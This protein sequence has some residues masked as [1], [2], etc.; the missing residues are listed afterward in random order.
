MF[1]WTAAHRCDGTITGRQCHVFGIV[2]ESDIPIHIQDKALPLR[3]TTLFYLTNILGKCY[4]IDALY[5]VKICNAPKKGHT[6]IVRWTAFSF[7]YGLH[8]LWH[9]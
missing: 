2:Q 4:L 6:L 7:D 3:H 1:G 9:F 8:S 5:F